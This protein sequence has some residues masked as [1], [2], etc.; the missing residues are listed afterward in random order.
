MDISSLLVRLPIE[1]LRLQLETHADF[2]ST[3]V[4][5]LPINQTR[6]GELHS[7]REK[8]HTTIV[9]QATTAKLFS[10]LL[11]MKGNLADLA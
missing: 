10:L 5:V 9:Y 11:R 6:E 2:V 4:H 1:S 8:C 3:A 7:C